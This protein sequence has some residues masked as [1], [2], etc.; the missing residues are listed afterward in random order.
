MDTTSQGDPVADLAEIDPAEAVAPAEKL[1]DELEADLAEDT[2]E[3]EEP[4]EQTTP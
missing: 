4:T 2:P 1:A 3:T